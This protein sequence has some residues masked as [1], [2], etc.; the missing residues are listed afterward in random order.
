MSDVFLCGLCVGKFFSGFTIAV[1]N[2]GTDD[3]CQVSVKHLDNFIVIMYSYRA[4]LWLDM[5]P[6]LRTNIA[7]Y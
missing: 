5:Q 3:L 2:Y 1:D 4:D 6:N 7:G